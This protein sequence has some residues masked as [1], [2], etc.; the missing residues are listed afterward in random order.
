MWVLYTLYIDQKRYKSNHFQN[1]QIKLPHVLTFARS[2]VKV[3]I[4]DDVEASSI[5]SALITRLFLLKLLITLFTGVQE[6]KSG[7]ASF[8][9]EKMF[10]HSH[11]WSL[12]QLFVDY[13]I[14]FFLAT[15]DA[16]KWS[17]SKNDGQNFLTQL[18]LWLWHQREC[19]PLVSS[20]PLFPG[21]PHS[22]FAV[23]NQK[24]EL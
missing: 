2:S 15:G 11:S 22:M 3:I 16:V 9:S 1:C 10:Y 21:L 24:L 5:W 7:H 8:I 12:D 13:L 23:S 20:R 18:Q 14:W 19:H 6:T 17:N 4:S